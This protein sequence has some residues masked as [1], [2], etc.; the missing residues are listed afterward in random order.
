MSQSEKIKDVRRRM[1]S[2]NKGIESLTL[3]DSAKQS[4]TLSLS[5]RVDHRMI[6]PS[7]RSILWVRG[8]LRNITVLKIVMM[9]FLNISGK[10]WDRRDSLGRSV[11][12]VL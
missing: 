5:A 4:P 8:S 1:D 11:A 7:P 10:V 6:S 2:S 3:N 12:V 9:I